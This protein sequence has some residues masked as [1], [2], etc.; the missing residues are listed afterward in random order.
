[1]LHMMR[2]TENINQIIY[3]IIN[4]PAQNCTELCIVDIKTILVNRFFFEEAVV[5]QLYIIF[6]RQFLFSCKFLFDLLLF[7]NSICWKVACR[8]F[9]CGIP[10]FRSRARSMIGSFSNTWFPLGIEPTLLN[11]MEQNRI[12]KYTKKSYVFMNWKFKH[13]CHNTNL[14]LIYCMIILY[15]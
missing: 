15:Y 9:N 11:Q 14:A 5:N 1:M 3:I 8:Y 6:Y 7:W 2:T 12:P 4:L 13:K 10:Y